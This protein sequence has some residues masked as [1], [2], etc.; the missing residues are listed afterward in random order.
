[1]TIP[2][3]QS[4]WTQYRAI[5]GLA[6][7]FAESEDRTDHA[8]LLSPRPESPFAFEPI[9][10]RLAERVRLVAIDLPGFG[11]SG[12]RVLVRVVF[13]G[14]VAGVDDVEL[15]LGQPLMEILGVDRRHGGR[16]GR[17]REDRS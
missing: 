8:R 9:W 11:H 17:L 4:I 5:D 10:P 16:A 14:E 15:A 7:R 13:P 6:V 12:R 2:L 3:S 1:M